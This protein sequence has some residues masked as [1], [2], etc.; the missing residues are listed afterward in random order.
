MQIFCMPLSLLQMLLVYWNLLIQQ[1]L[2]FILPWSN[3]T[4]CILEWR[5][6]SLL[7]MSRLALLNALSSTFVTP[8]SPFEYFCGPNIKILVY[9]KTMVQVGWQKKWF[10]W[11]CCRILQN[12]SV[13]Q[14]TK[15]CKCILLPR[16]LISCLVLIQFHF[17][18]QHQS[19][20]PNWGT[21]PPWYSK[22]KDML[23]QRNIV[24][25]YVL[26]K[27]KDLQPHECGKFENVY[28]D[29][30]IWQDPFLIQ[31]KSKENEWNLVM[32]TWFQLWLPLWWV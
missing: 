1:L 25:W 17:G 30:M 26:Y 3:F 4:I 14:L 7:I 9:Q 23:H 27:D 22:W 6:T 13:S 24:L 19:L 28:Y 10:N 2:P 20:I 16:R 29:T 15:V 21:L 11:Q 8:F 12:P 5:A 31:K 32:T 18:R